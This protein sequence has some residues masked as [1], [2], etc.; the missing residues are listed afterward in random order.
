MPDDKVSLLTGRMRELLNTTG[1]GVLIL[2]ITAILTALVGA[3]PGIA[4]R[5]P[6][7]PP[8]EHQL[9][10]TLKALQENS[11]MRFLC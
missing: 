10:L 1:A 11:A 9:N 5:T 4:G 6:S 3:F 2:A 8:T 7:A